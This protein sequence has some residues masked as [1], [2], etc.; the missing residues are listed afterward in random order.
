MKF[1]GEIKS[2]SKYNTEYSMISEKFITGLGEVQVYEN[3]ITKHKVMI[4][5]LELE[6]KE[7]L[8]EKYSYLL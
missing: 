8:K 5:I 7:V 6:S 3:P 1:T 2:N 4:N